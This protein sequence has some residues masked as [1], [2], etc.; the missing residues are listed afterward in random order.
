MAS[1]TKSPGAVEQKGAGVDWFSPTDAVLADDV[2]ATVSLTTGQES[3][4]ITFSDFGFTFPTDA[5]L[6]GFKVSLRCGVD[7]VG[8]GEQIVAF[9]AMAT[10]DPL[11]SKTAAP[12]DYFGL[13]PTM[14]LG[15][16]DDLWSTELTAEDVNSADFCVKIKAGIV[17]ITAAADFYLDDVTITVTYSGGTVQTRSAGKVGIGV[18][19]GI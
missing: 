14:E 17:D 8:T 18:G 1:V 15:A 2:P 13:D 5:T 7:P 4:L 10:G 9:L 6:L 11:G 19:V 16:N 3:T 12:P